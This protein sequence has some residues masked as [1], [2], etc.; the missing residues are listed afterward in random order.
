MSSN[1]FIPQPNRYS[2][3]FQI[4]SQLKKIQLIWSCFEYIPNEIITKIMVLFTILSIH[5]NNIM[6]CKESLC[7]DSWCDVM[8]YKNLNI[9]HSIFHCISCHII[10]DCKYKFNRCYKCYYCKNIV[11]FSCHLLTLDLNK[12]V[13]KDIC[14]L[15]DKDKI[16]LSPLKMVDK[17]K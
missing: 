13:P 3:N 11:C 14:I 17:Q 9:D 16:Q 1:V 15:C 12:R 5:K 7:I 4:F 8:S 10:K 2:F 6:K